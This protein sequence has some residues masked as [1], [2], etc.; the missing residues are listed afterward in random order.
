MTPNPS[1]IIWN[2]DLILF[3]SISIHSWRFHDMCWQLINCKSEQLALALTG[4]GS[5]ITKIY[6]CK[7]VNNYHE[8][9]NYHKVSE[10]QQQQLV[11][12]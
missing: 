6:L 11:G 7:C 8:S 4:S 10:Q 3:I 5:A 1:N 12:V 2:D 9:Q